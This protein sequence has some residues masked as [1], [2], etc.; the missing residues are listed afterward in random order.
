MRRLYSEISLG[1]WCVLALI[2]YPLCR[3]QPLAMNQVK[4]FSLAVGQKW[5]P[6][7]AKVIDAFLNLLLRENI[8]LVCCRVLLVYTQANNNN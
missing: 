5:M 8:V 4:M 6:Y 1:N 3:V 2:H 7:N